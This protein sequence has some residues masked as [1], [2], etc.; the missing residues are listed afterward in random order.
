GH[1]AQLLTTSSTTTTT[2]IAEP[3]QARP[4][5][6]LTMRLLP[7]AGSPAVATP[8]AVAE[9]PPVQVAEEPPVQ[10]AEAATWRVR[11]GES[12]WSIA[13][14]VLGDAW[15]RPATDAEIVPYWQ[16]LIETNRAV[17]VD[18][19]NPDLIFPGQVFTVPAVPAA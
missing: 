9:E 8:P 4:P 10:M 17:L 16:V 19:A 1:A 15:G 7:E 2:A 3:G 11:P 12:F 5:P 14:D 6:T 18:E 13:E